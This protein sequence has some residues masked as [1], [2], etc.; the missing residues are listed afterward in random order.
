ML[1]LHN[2]IALLE[3]HSFPDPE[4]CFTDDGGEWK[5]VKELLPFSSSSGQVR[6]AGSGAPKSQRAPEKVNRATKVLALANSE[7][8]VGPGHS[9]APQV[10]FAVRNISTSYGRGCTDTCWFLQSAKHLQALPWRPPLHKHM[11]QTLGMA[12]GTLV[13][14]I[15][16]CTSFQMMFAK[17]PKV[18]QEHPKPSTAAAISTDPVW[19][20]PAG[21]SAEQ[22]FEE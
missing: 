2:I 12:E 10:T 8:T 6:I 15:K 19:V 18:C 11:W 17:L 13:S 16:P 1:A 7:E 20:I 21:L 9:A 14:G 4:W 5:R 3:L 22:I